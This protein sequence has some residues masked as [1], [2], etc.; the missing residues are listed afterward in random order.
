MTSFFHAPASTRSPYRVLRRALL[1]AAVMAL[2]MAPGLSVAGSSVVDEPPCE[3]PRAEKL[4][5]D[6]EIVCVEP[7]VE[8]SG[9]SEQEPSSSKEEGDGPSDG[10]D[11]EQQPASGD[12][13]WKEGD[14]PGPAGQ[15]DSEEAGD[16]EGG[17]QTAGE[18]QADRDGKARRDGKR[19][20]ERE[21]RGEREQRAERRPRDER[22]PRRSAPRAERSFQAPAPQRVLAPRSGFTL[23]GP[24][25]PVDLMIDEPRIPSFLVPIYKAAAK[26]YDIPWTI[27]AAINEI[28]TDYGRNVAVSSAGARGWMQFMP[29]SWRAFGVDA[30]DDGE[31]DPNDP[32]DAI[33]A[34]ARYLDEHGAQDDLRRALFAYNHAGWYVDSVLIRAERISATYKERDKELRTLLRRNRDRLERQVLEDER[35]EIYGCG[36]QDIAAHRIDRR[37]LILLRYLAN[38]GLHPTVT[39]LTCG[40]GI[41]T[42]SGNV[43]HH[44]TGS[45]VDIAAI[46][47][48]RIEPASQGK[49][50]ITDLTIR[51]LL[52]LDG[53]MR[54]DQIISLMKYR[55][56][57]NTFAMG[58]HADHLHVGFR[59]MSDAGYEAMDGKPLISQAGRRALG[60]LRP[61]R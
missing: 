9:P 28:E 48:K 31:K 59:P 51:E 37:V 35:I 25:L 18:E 43:S 56:H 2:Y 46:N 24:L 40:H 45:A 57:D 1:V 36:R 19:Q 4:L 61:V 53:L 12:G 3:A 23:D 55:K 11:S 30:N 16:V 27:L 29:A 33:F 15:P 41:Y 6:G 47:G 17:Q 20:G 32:E 13:S 21:G 54:P 7:P 44:T 49:G 50:S 38:S 52:A 34:A 60:G 8:D 14:E 5:E 39:S 22:R 42:K 58:D 10:G 26:K